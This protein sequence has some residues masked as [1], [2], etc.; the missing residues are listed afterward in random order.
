M[1]LF[2][3][4]LVCCAVLT[5]RA[6]IYK[7]VDASGQVTY[8]DR[9]IK[10]ARRLNLGPLPAA[11]RAA[12]SAQ[13]N[14]ATREPIVFPRVDASTQNRRDDLRRSILQSEL[15]T[16]E[17]ALADAVAAKKAGVSPHAGELTSSPAYVSRTDKLEGAV[18]LHRDNI[19]ALG[20]ELGSIR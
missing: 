16:E 9:P 11:A 5:A 18:K 15:H 8:T 7:S 12:H 10:G 1:R 6:D 13:K 20:K 19:R 17:Q 14:A 4:V 2:V 3:L